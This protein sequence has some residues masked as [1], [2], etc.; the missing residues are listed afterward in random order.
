MTGDFKAPNPWQISCAMHHPCATLLSMVRSVCL[1][2]ARPCVTCRR[3]IVIPLDMI[4]LGGTD[5]D[6]GEAGWRV[7]LSAMT[8]AH[9]LRE[10]IG[11]RDFVGATNF[12]PAAV[13]VD[14]GWPADVLHHTHPHV[15]FPK[16]C[17]AQCASAPGLPD[18]S[19][20]TAS[21][22]AHDGGS[23]GVCGG[24][25]DG[26]IEDSPGAGAGA[27]TSADV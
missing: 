21:V 12:D 8:G 17:R 13:L 3:C 23:G 24:A 15:H 18:V 20:P 5:C 14:L 11:I 26:A 4:I 22:G 7:I 10:V 1:C 6:F 25:G 19:T 16:F 2:V 9:N 27:G